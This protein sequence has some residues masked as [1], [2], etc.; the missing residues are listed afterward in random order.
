MTLNFRKIGDTGPH[1][2]ILHGVFGSADNWMTFQKELANYGY[3]VWAFDARNHGQS[4]WADAFSYDLM[5]ADLKNFLEQHAIENPTIIGH[6]M[7]GKTLLT[8]LASHQNLL[9][10]AIV[11]DIAP[12][13]YPTHH[14]HILQ[15][16][17]KINLF[18]YTSRADVE[19]AFA[20]FVPGFGERQFLLKN[21]TRVDGAFTWR[22][23]HAVIGR[24]IY[25]IGSEI[26][27][28]KPNNIPTLFIRGELSNY[29]EDSDIATIKQSF[30]DV[31]FKGIPDAGHWVQAEQPVAFLEAVLKFLKG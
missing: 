31:H 7:G 22:I 5:A 3:Q 27:F 10:K 17:N 15:A 11:V 2:V 14:D 13:Y 24:E 4:P 18:L 1:V 23:N 28:D 6:S 8:F 19:A 25:Q 29:I 16:F 20:A 21:L 30:K 26:L 9:N 12:K